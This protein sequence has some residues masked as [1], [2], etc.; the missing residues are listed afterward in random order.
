MLQA[1]CCR[2][3]GMCFDVD[4]E[5]KVDVLCRLE[6]TLLCVSDET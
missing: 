2:L 5:A 6:Y 3:D 1:A 4:V